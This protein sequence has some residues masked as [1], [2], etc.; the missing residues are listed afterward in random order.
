MMLT[1]MKIVDQMIQIPLCSIFITP[2]RKNY[3]FEEKMVLQV[4][5]SYKP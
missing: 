1:S 5:S 4:R 3:I 2:K